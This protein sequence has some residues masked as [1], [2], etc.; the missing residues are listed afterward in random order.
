V[1][2]PRFSSST[3]INNVKKDKKFKINVR[4]ALGVKDH[5]NWIYNM[6]IANV[7]NMTPMNTDELSNHNEGVDLV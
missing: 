6:N 4:N 5:A 7:M 3:Q 1:I 2:K